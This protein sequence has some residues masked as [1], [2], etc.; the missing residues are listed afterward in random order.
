MRFVRLCELWDTKADS[1]VLSSSVLTSFN[2]WVQL[3]MWRHHIHAISI[4]NKVSSRTIMRQC[5]VSKIHIMPSY[6]MN[7]SWEHGRT[8]LTKKPTWRISAALP[9]HHD[10]RFLPKM[11]QRHVHNISIL[12]LTTPDT[13]VKA[14]TAPLSAGLSSISTTV[15]PPTPSNAITGSRPFLHQWTCPQSIGHWNI[16]RTYR[17]ISVPPSIFIHARQYPNVIFLSLLSYPWHQYQ[18]PSHSQTPTT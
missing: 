15:L 4:T 6:S 1:D 13:V 5:T 17:E 18:N 14:A 10:E 7:R 9:E 2:A 16:P 8:V 3:S 12:L 11:I